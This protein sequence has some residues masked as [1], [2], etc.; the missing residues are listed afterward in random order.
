M[1]KEKLYNYFVR[2]NGRVCYEYE[3]YVREHLVEHRLHRLRHLRLLLKL[4]WH[5]CVK[6][7][8]LPFLYWDEAGIINTE[9]KT[10]IQPEQINE[11]NV[12]N[13]IESESIDLPDA[14]HFAKKLMRYNVISFDIFDTLLFRKVA[15]PT[16]VF[17]FIQIKNKIEKFCEER[18]KAEI[19]VRNR[20]EK[21]SGNREV[22]IFDIYKYLERRTG[23]NADDGVE[24]EFE[25]ECALC[26]ANPYMAEVFELVK[27]QGKKIIL[28]SDMYYPSEMLD[29]LLEKCGI[30][31]Y[32]KIYVSCEYGCNKSK[33]DL[34]DIVIAEN[35]KS[36]MIHVGDN[37]VSDVKIPRSIGINVQYYPNV[38]DT[39]QKYRIVTRAMSDYVGSAYASLINRYIRNGLQKYKIMYEYGFIY[40]GIYVLGYM[41]WVHE[42][43]V[44]NKVDKVLFLSRDGYIYSKVFNFLFEDIPNEY[45]YWSRS[46]TAR[47]AVNNNR[48]PLINYILLAKTE[49]KGWLKKAFDNLYISSILD[50]ISTTKIYEMENDKEMLSAFLNAN[51]GKICDLLDP[52]IKATVDELDKSVEKCKSVA[53][54]DVGWNGSSAEQIRNLLGESC[55]IYS[56]VV[57]ALSNSGEYGKIQDNQQYAYAF[58]ESDNRTLYDLF[59]KNQNRVA[60]L[61]ELFT[62]AHSPMFRGYLFNK[63][64]I[65]YDFFDTKIGMYE[66][67]DQIHKGILDFC[68][69]WK[70]SFIDYSFM[71]NISGWDAINPFRVMAGDKYYVDNQLKEFESITKNN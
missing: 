21:Y 43:A 50:G 26:E 16:D 4:N 39:G 70:E 55:T 44:K 66:E 63:N 23:I 71:F 30:R 32:S 29:K 25:T 13:G 51:W 5:Y 19:E 47:V 10:N 36:N 34:F 20:K 12:F 38:N 22:T 35:G 37:R 60:A 27:S 62:Q 9:K 68:K 56:L 53:I 59:R 49:E 33:G 40:G 1:I 11:G 18:K 8:T 6:K 67:I 2:K 54:V 15:K 42:F 69:I 28:V 58:S 46:V 65:V 31:G 41:S 57:G 24:L 3:R 61:F 17:L 45:V 14:Y 48:R 64:K 7:N 52:S